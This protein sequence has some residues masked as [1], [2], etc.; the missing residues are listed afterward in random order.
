[1]SN[2]IVT[3][4]EEGHKTIVMCEHWIELVADVVLVDNGRIVRCAHRACTQ[5]SRRAARSFELR[6]RVLRP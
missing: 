2:V 5:P 6:G 1:V 4:P 3:L